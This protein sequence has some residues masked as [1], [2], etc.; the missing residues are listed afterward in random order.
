MG[1][2]RG[3]T[4]YAGDDDTMPRT[5]PRW[6]IIMCNPTRNW[7]YKSLVKP[8][9]DYKM[10]IS[11][12]NLFVNPNTGEPW[13]EIFEGSTYA[14]AGNLEKDF[15]QG[16][17]A[18]YKGQMKSRFLDGGWEAY[19]GLIYPDYRQNVHML[20][21]EDMLELYERIIR[22]GGNRDNILEGYDH[23]VAKPACYLF[24]FT[25]PVGDVFIMDGFY[26]KEQSISTS[27]RMMRD[28]R[29]KYGFGN[30]IQAA[31]FQSASD[32]KVLADPSI[33]RRVSGNSA[34]VGT[35]TSGLFREH[36]IKMIR[37]NNDVL[38]G[39]AKVQS[40]LYID[41]YHR[42]PVDTTIVGAPRIYFSKHLEFIDSEISDYY[43]KKD[44][45]GEYED[46]PTDRNDHAMDT[47]KY[48]LSKRPRVA[49]FRAGSK[50]SVLPVKYSHWREQ[51]E[52]AQASGKKHRYG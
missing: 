41:P 4:P 21:Y 36:D 12:P 31:S 6:F 16:L 1:R 22:F 13:I 42:H 3:Q 40:Y 18:R 8:V 28:T 9:H 26:E 5:G 29:L 38:N 25:N 45:A 49:T 33:F 46:V 10:G 17:E 24:G 44:T 47:I 51:P 19:E 11:N 50:P 39:I 7:V 37:G 14:N 32:L 15:I 43:W 27:A 30:G 23:G 20:D 52:M 48:I 34:T 2:L 35:T